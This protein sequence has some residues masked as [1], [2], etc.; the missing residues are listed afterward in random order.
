MNTKPMSKS[1][2]LILM[3]RYRLAVIAHRDA[4]YSITYKVN[5][6][7]TFGSISQET[8]AVYERSRIQLLEVEEELRILRR[9]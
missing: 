8:I 3:E 2:V 5:G 6:S 4:V 9:C 7:P 1:E